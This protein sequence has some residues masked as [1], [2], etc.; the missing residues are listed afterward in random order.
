MTDVARSYGGKSADE[1]TAARRARLVDATIE[2]LAGVGEART[3]MTAICARAGLTERYFY[4][5][6]GYRDQA[7]VAALDEISDE[8]ARTALEAVAASSGESADRVRATIGAVVDFVVDAPEAVRV[9]V[10]EST[11]NEALRTRR[12]ELLGSFAALVATEAHGLFGD[13]TWPPPRDHLQG[14]IFIAG[15]SELVASWLLGEVEMTP[16][17]LVSTASDSLV[18]LM[19][20][21]P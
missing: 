21:T 5:S 15:L 1:R 20:R 14:V 9:A 10:I 3:T 17:E 11:A 2:L 18:A 13:E 7:L 6:F 8:I 19:R 12:H 16:E 4:E